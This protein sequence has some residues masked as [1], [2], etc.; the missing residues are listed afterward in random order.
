MSCFLNISGEKILR[1]FKNSLATPALENGFLVRISP[2]P[3]HCLPL[4]VSQ[5]VLKQEVVTSHL[6][7]ILAKVL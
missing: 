4:P 7:G 3:A 2:F 1:T 6:L 5:E